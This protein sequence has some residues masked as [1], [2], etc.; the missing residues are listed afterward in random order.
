MPELRSDELHVCMM[1]KRPCTS[2]QHIVISLLLSPFIGPFICPRITAQKP[3]CVHVLKFQLGSGFRC[4]LGIS[5]AAITHFP[6]VTNLFKRS[7]LSRSII[8]STFLFLC[9]SFVIYFPFFTR[10]N[11]KTEK[12]MKIIQHFVCIRNKQNKIFCRPSKK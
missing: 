10:I 1:N 11:R 5:S 7:T 6:P 12:N 8:Q 2:Q 3:S 9:S 4:L